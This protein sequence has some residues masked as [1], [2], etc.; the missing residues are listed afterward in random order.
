MGDTALWQGSTKHGWPSL[1][2]VMESQSHSDCAPLLEAVYHQSLVHPLDSLKLKKSLKNLLVFL[3]G[4]GRS[5]ANCWAVDLFFAHSEG[6]ERDWVEQNLPEEFHDVLAM[7][8]R[9]L[10]CRWR[11]NR[12]TGD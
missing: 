3:S 11:A 8:G 7:M 5:N 2:P 9:R 4:E 6:W 1:I 12:L 10:G